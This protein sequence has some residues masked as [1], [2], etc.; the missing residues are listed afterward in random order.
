[1]AFRRDSDEEVASSLIAL[2]RAALDRWGRGD[3]SG[4]LEISAPDVVYFDPY[5]PRRIDGLLELTR[6]YEKL[7]GKVHVSRFEMLR[8]RVQRAGDMAVL[9]FNHV[10]YGGNEVESRWNCT[11]VYRKDPEGWR[12]VQTH[13]S[14]TEV[15][16]SSPVAA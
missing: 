14:Y 7:R 1:M 6:H 5:V 16:K 10:S 15:G 3:P 11:E 2:E 9:T 12:I 4:F 8:P 13:W